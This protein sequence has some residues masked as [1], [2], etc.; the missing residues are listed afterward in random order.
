MNR[1]ESKM[2]K[3][4]DSSRYR[5]CDATTKR[6]EPCRAPAKPGSDLCAF[7]SDPE[8]ARRI[9]ALGGQAKGERSRAIKAAGLAGLETPRS[10]TQCIDTIN[11]VFGR[12]VAQEIE[13]TTA[14]A[15]AI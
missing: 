6:G 11:T 13:P 8:A 12:L 10:I 3:Q 15:I 1:K 9:A 7:H 4:R 2:A 14:A 5:T